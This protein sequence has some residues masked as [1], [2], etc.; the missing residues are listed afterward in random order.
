VA[1]DSVLAIVRGAAGLVGVNQP[2]TATGSTDLQINQLLALANVEGQE[3]AARFDWQVLTL[4]KTFTSVATE[5]QGKINGTIVSSAL[6]FDHIL[7]DTVWNRSTKIGPGGPLSATSWQAIKSTTYAGPWA[8]YRIRGGELLLIP[9]PAAGQTLA[10]EYKSVNWVSNVTNDATRASFTADDD[11]PLLDS[12][13]IKLGLIWRWKSAKGLEYAQDFQ[14]YE[15]A[16]LDAMTRDTPH[17]SV[18]LNGKMDEFR[19]M[20]QVPRG[21]YGL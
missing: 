16:V 15:N 18:N 13:L 3:L 12:R 1:S 9:A 11:Y 17:V 5:S 14:N 4:E 10:F 2:T 7:N 19:P 8:Q 6:G 21:N 20:I